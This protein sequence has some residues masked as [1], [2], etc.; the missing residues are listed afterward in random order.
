M[1]K[2]IKKKFLNSN[3]YEMVIEAPRVSKNCMPGQFVILKIDEV[4][5]RIP[6]TIADYNREKG[7]IT[8][9]VQAVGV[10]T[11]KLSHLEEG[12]YIEDFVR[13]YRNAI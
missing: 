3:T 2:I 10:S 9:V 13:S 6:L 5:E 4:G 11:T 1:Y 8:I 12:D 7:T